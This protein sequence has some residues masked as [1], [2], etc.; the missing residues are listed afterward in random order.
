MP[1]APAAPPA[2]TTPPAASIDTNQTGVLRKPG[3][4]T[5]GTGA[6]A[7]SAGAPGDA[8]APTSTSTNTNGTG[9]STKAASQGGGGG[10]DSGGTL[11]TVLIALAI[12]AVAV[13]VVAGIVLKRRKAHQDR[14]LASLAD[15]RKVTL[16]SNR[17]PSTRGSTRQTT[18]NATFE[19]PWAEGERGNDDAPGGDGDGDGYLCVVAGT[20]ADPGHVEDVPDCAAMQP[21]SP[22]AVAKGNVQRAANPLYG[23]SDE[24]DATSAKSK[25]QRAANPLYAGTG[26]DDDGDIYNTPANTANDAT[27]TR[28]TDNRNTNNDNNN[29][30]GGGGVAQQDMSYAGLE[31]DINDGWTPG[32]KAAVRSPTKR[33]RPTDKG[34]SAH[35]SAG[36]QAQGPSAYERM[37]GAGPGAPGTAD[38]SQYAVLQQGGGDDNSAAPAPTSSTLPESDAGKAYGEVTLFSGPAKAASRT[39]HTNAGA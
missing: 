9:S 6:P 22:A 11:V 12:L 35:G 39:S 7:S 15:S 20:A 25:V 8:S 27:A 32:G 10:G 18:H 38:D 3:P 16:A 33:S 37:M 23:A 30:G 36:I 5:D 14:V 17:T 19:I 28:S 1:T 21:R 26:D 24:A 13:F 34:S 29:L 4:D 2:R 31:P